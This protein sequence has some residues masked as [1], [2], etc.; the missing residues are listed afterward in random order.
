MLRGNHQAQV[1]SDQMVIVMARQGVL[2]AL[3]VAKSSQ[4]RVRINS[5]EQGG[6]LKNMQRDSLK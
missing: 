4:M 2:T 5:R 3:T 1:H 6:L